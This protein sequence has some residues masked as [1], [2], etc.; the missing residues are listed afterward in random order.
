MLVRQQGFVLVLALILSGLMSAIVLYCYQTQWMVN[1]SVRYF[2]N[3]A[4]AFEQAQSELLALRVSAAASQPVYVSSHYHHA[5]V[6][7]MWQRG[8]WHYVDSPADRIE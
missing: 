3:Y 5:R 6:R 8:C 4:H 7:L 2:D 1:Q